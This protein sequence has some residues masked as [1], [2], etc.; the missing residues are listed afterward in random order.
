[1][2]RL[3]AGLRKGSADGAGAAASA[4]ADDLMSRD[5]QASAAATQKAQ[6]ARRE[7]MDSVLTSSKTKG[8]AGDASSSGSTGE[9]PPELAGLV[10]GLGSLVEGESSFDYLKQYLREMDGDDSLFRDID[11]SVIPLSSGS[12]P[13]R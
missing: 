4:V 13:P 10:A 11:P 7:K 9:V 8:Q 2:L 6:L 3:D 12:S 5:P 1:L